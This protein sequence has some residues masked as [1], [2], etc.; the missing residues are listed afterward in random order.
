MTEY[1]ALGRY[2]DIDPP[3]IVDAETTAREIQ[4]HRQRQVELGSAIDQLVGSVEDA[5]TEPRVKHFTHSLGAVVV[6]PLM[7]DPAPGYWDQPGMEG[8]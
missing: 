1:E 2:D 8:A 5:V 3:E 6:E 4:G 7:R